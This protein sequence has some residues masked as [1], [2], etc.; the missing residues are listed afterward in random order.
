MRV[1]VRSFCPYLL[2]PIEGARP[3]TRSRTIQYV[4]QCSL[5]E[6]TSTTPRALGGCNASRHVPLGAD[7][8][9]CLTPEGALAVS[10]S[11]TQR[12]PVSV[13]GTAACE[14]RGNSVTADGSSRIRTLCKTIASTGRASRSAPRRHIDRRSDRAQ[15][16]WACS[17][18]STGTR[19]TPHVEP[20]KSRP[21]SGSKTRSRKPGPTVTETPRGWRVERR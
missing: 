14:N 17:R 19:Y 4:A 5:A 11:H 21:R 8:D 12:R 2:A 7:C 15:R 3:P 13:A 6:S 18:E 20:E 10:L 16:A 9:L 1:R